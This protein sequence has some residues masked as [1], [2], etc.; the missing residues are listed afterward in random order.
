MNELVLRAIR[1]KKNVFEYDL[2]DMVKFAYSEY[3][4]K[5][6]VNLREYYLDESGTI[7]PGRW[8]VHICPT[9]WSR[10]LS[11]KLDKIRK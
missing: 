10:A 6:S 1:T 2:S 7:M 11:P 5:W 3:R 9:V 4:N 8:G